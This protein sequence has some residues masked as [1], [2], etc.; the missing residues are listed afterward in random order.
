LPIT[1]SY[2]PL[3]SIISGSFIVSH[4]L[5]YSGLLQ[6]SSVFCI[7]VQSNNSRLLFYELLISEGLQNSS[8]F[9]FY[10]QF[11]NICLRSDF[12]F[13]FRCSCASSMNV[14]ILLPFIGTHITYWP[15]SSAHYVPKESAHLLFCCNCL[16]LCFMLAS[17][18]LH[19]LDWFIVLLVC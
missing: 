3:A 14:H 17:R 1:L 19:A 18:C 13:H 4:S 7:A 12:I 8:S 6:R 15:S 5:L 9:L 10:F 2:P 11:S 16:G